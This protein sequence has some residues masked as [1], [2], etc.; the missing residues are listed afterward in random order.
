MTPCRLT[1]FQDLTYSML[2]CE[3]GKSLEILKFFTNLNGVFS[4]RVKHKQKSSEEPR[5]LPKN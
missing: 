2:K 3:E 4:G 1:E 5:R